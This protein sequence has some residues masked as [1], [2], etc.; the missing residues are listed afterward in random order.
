MHDYEVE[1]PELTP[2]AESGEEPSAHTQQTPEQAGETGTEPDAQPEAAEEAEAPAEG[3]EEAQSPQAAE[4]AGDEAAQPEPAAPESSP[5]P[6]TTGSYGAPAGSGAP[7]KAAKKKSHGVWK[8]LLAAALVVVLV[9][10]ACGI[11]ASQVNSRWSSEKAL[12]DRQISALMQ[13]VAALEEEIQSSSYTGQGNSISGTS[14]TGMD[15][16]LTPAQVYAKCVDSVVIITN[17]T[18]SGISTGSGVILTED[19]YIATNYHVVEDAVTLSVTT[20]DST[21]YAAEY[22]GGDSANDVAVIKIDAQ[23]LSAATIGS[24]SDLIVGDQVVAI[25]NPLGELTSTLT[26]GYVSAKDRTIT[27]DGTLINML[28]TDAAINAGN[29][30][31]PLFNMNGEVIGIT[32][33][34]YSGTTSSGASIEGIGFA[35][36]IDDVIHKITDLVNYGYITGA[37]LGVQVTNMDSSVAE[38]YNIPVGVYVDSVLDGYCAQAAGVQSKDIILA[39]GDTSVTIT[40]DL[41]RAL[42]SYSA[43]DTTTITV[44]RS[45]TTLVLDI[46]LDERPHD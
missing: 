37:Y 11:T 28:Q 17:T 31:G 24:S 25:G 18:A 41:T 26:V 29:S 43:G 7:P 3:T 27:T 33:A 35:I 36:P 34:K 6:F 12:T 19:G 45:G 21:S 23:G 39:L 46:T 38:Y 44:W 1:F 2:K 30:G 10:T 5:L 9:A 42:Q 16:G 14:N 40:N 13:Q 32:T 15:G 20:N 22:I 8:A 4:A